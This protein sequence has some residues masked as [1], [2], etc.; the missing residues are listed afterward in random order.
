MSKRHK[1][2]LKNSRKCSDQK[3]LVW[4][5]NKLKPELDTIP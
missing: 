4:G 5:E 1:Q 3:I 2:T